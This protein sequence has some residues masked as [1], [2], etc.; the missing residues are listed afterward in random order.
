MRRLLGVLRSDPGAAA[1]AP[2]GLAA[3]P[4]RVEAAGAA[5]LD[6]TM[7]ST[8]RPG[9]GTATP[10]V[11]QCA[12]RI[13][14]EAISNA[15]RHAPGA[16]IRVTVTTDDRNLHVSVHNTD[17]GPSPVARA[18]PAAGGGHGLAGMRERVGAL[19]GELTAGPARAGGIEVC[20]VLPL[21]T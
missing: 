17:P 8:P 1:A 7:T 14:Q 13:V 6:V 19:G 18:W 9:A 5:G 20:A 16:A 10:A 3:I 12:Y 4:A 21:R 15:T 11:E 2:P